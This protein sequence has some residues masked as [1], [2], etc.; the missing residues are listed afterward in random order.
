MDENNPK[1]F[2]QLH[3]DELQK[4]A[5]PWAEENPDVPIVRIHLYRYRYTK[6]ETIVQRKDP[7]R[8]KVQYVVVFEIPGL[9]L[10]LYRE[11]HFLYSDDILEKLPWRDFMDKCDNVSDHFYPKSPFIY[12]MLELVYKES[13]QSDFHRNWIFIAVPSEGPLPKYVDD[14]VFW[15]L[16]KAKET[17]DKT[18]STKK[19]RPN[20]RHKITVRE[21]AAELWEKDPDITIGGYN[22]MIFRDEINEVCEGNVYA[23]KTLRN[24]IKDLCP[25]RKPGRRSIK[26]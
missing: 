15:V 8:R 22:G 13:P 26:A 11:R 5:K 18:T 24:W 23:E 6:T 2:L 4:Y 3:F 12:P 14:T 25:N 16:W 20:Q 10:E 7:A 17:A 1:N 21:V 9:D 19:L